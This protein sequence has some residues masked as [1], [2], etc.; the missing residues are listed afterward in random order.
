MGYHMDMDHDTHPTNY[1]IWMFT[2]RPM[3]SQS[4]QNGDG[5]CRN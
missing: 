2:P 5:S 1:N 4:C 3:V